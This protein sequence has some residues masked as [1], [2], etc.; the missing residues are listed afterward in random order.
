M[1]RMRE[2]QLAVVGAGPTALWT[3][4]LS[5]TN[6]VPGYRL[7]VVQYMGINNVRGSFV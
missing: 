7:Q 3:S 6:G 5:T 1:A 2:R 4:S